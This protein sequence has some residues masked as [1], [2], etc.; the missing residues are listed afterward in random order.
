[1]QEEKIDEL[2]F[3]DQIII[4]D[5]DNVVELDEK[6]LYE[7]AADIAVCVFAHK[8]DYIKLGGNAV[9]I[10]CALELLERVGTAAYGKNSGFV[11]Q[12]ETMKA[13]SIK[14]TKSEIFAEMIKTI[15]DGVASDEEIAKAAEHLRSD[16]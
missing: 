9:S 8:G 11:R 15:I 7:I 6:R 1:M 5:S 12:I 4:I 3:Y 10:V 2:M 14:N 16:A 13:K